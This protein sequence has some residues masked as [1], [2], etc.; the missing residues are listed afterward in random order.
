MVPNNNANSDERR[1]KFRKSDLTFK[2]ILILFGVIQTGIGWGLREI[3]NTMKEHDRAIV[4][5]QRD[6]ANNTSIY[7]VKYTTIENLTADLKTRLNKIDD[8][9]DS[10]ID[11]LPRR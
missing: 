2:V 4:A 7:T 9:I 3:W 10:I 8:K 6:S 11:R 1:D 5:L